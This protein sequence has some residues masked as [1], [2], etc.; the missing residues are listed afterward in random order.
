MTA[1]TEARDMH[2]L[3]KRIMEDYKDESPEVFLGA[4]CGVAGWVM[5]SMAEGSPAKMKKIGEGFVQ[6]VVQNANTKMVNDAM[7]RKRGG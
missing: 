5:C 2:L 6:S 3:A 7:A 1:P 4:L